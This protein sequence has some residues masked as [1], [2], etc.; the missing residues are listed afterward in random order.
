MKHLAIII[1]ML[2]LAI[3]TAAQDFQGIATYKSHRKMDIQLDSTQMETEMHKQMIEMMKKQFE[4]TYILAFNKE[5][6][7][8]KEE[9]QLEAPQPAGM[10]MVM[11]NTG[12]SGELYKNTKE[13]R[14][15]DQNEMFGKVFLIEDK[16]Q[17]L[18]W[19]LGS[20]TKNIGEYT[21]YKATMKRQVE[22]VVG[23]ISV[24]GDKDLD[25]EA[26]PEMEE[27]TITAWYTPQIPVNNGPR[28]Y[29]GLP[30]LIL[31]VNDGRETLICSKIVLNPKDKISITEPTKGKKVTQEIFDAI[32]EKKM[33]EMEERYQHNR[34]DG[35][36]I[37]IKIRG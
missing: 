19:E 30:G 5:E 16:L 24:N 4:K 10:V 17:K 14:Y 8:Y 12:D 11:V 15:T 36:S 6:S 1:V 20:E 23:E 25:T 35:N 29:H 21:C 31:E 27:I 7:L 34:D 2:L 22:T 18:D 26:E 28:K 33:K 3:T 32:M 13:E 9:E 37:E